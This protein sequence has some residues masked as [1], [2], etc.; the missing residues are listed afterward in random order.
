MR[1]R[2]GFAVG[3]VVGYVLGSRAGRERYDELKR[4][5]GKVAENPIAQS[6][7]AAV[8][9]QAGRVEVLVREKLGQPT[10]G[11]EVVAEAAADV[12]P[13]APH[14]ESQSAALDHMGEAIGEAWAESID[15][16]EADLPE[17]E[18]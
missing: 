17:S 9:E 2:I 1:M 7:S 10:T 4:A 6:A 16:T 18:R 5:A 13:E 11:A 15:A 14:E 12:T 3:A 8:Q